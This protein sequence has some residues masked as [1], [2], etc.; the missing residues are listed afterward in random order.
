MTGAPPFLKRTPVRL[1]ATFTALFAITVVALF[2]VLYFGITTR[3]TDQIRL[4]TQETMDALL[5]IDR[6]Q[7]FDDLVAVVKGEGGSVRDADFIIELV[8]GTGRH[9]AG[10]VSGIRETDAWLSLERSS[11]EADRENGE[12]DDRFLAVW[13]PVSKGRLLVGSSNRELR[14]TQA[15]LLEVLG[16]G[17]A[18]TSLI[19]AL[20]GAFLAAR[21]HHRIDAFANTLSAVSE[22]R[23][24]ARV[25][26]SGSGDDI[27][28]VG[29]Q[30]NRTLDHLQKLIESVN[31][32]SS[33]IAHDMKKPVGR[34]RQRLDIARRSARTTADFRAAVEDALEDLDSMMETFDA[35]LRITQIEAGARRARFANVDLG[36]VLDDVADVYA[37]VAEDAGHR[38]EWA[39]ARWKPAVVKGDRELLIQ[40]FANLIENAI[41][42]CPPGTRIALA[43][44][45]E[46]Q[47]FRAEL[48]DDG[49]GIPQDER[50]KVFRRLYR[51]ERARSTPGSGLGLTLAAAIAELHDAHIALEDHAPGLRVA[52]RFP[53]A[54][55][56]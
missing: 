28:H 41:R 55:A 15:F 19:G 43:L 38:L 30:V 52:V 34:L 7:G 26:M 36:A 32:S 10:N 6:Q 50:E 54:A 31:Q 47:G 5:T 17:L 9:V 4:R 13:Q 21:T 42:H 23:I 56:A 37:A 20:C 14:R 11:I 33:D 8:D 49:P 1:A 12:P 18:A 46:P 45:D 24:A 29:A 51:L 3:L 16:I 25:P 35:L 22:G 27:D 48:M 40:L 44:H 53:G 2:A 39:D